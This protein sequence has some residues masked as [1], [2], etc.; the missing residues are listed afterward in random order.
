M[1]ALNLNAR[2]GRRFHESQQLSVVAAVISKRWSVST[3]AAV[4]GINHQTVKYMRSGRSGKYKEAHK[5][6]TQIGEQQFVKLYLE[7][8]DED[9]LNNFKRLSR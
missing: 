6:I 8:R 9:R 2:Y 4:Y 3:I 1:F 7:K 5:I